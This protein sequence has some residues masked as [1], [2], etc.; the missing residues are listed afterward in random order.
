MHVQWPTQ[1]SHGF[2][3]RNISLNLEAKGELFRSLLTC[4]LGT[5]EARVVFV[6]FYFIL[7]NHVSPLKLGQDRT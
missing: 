1:F 6:L 7:K 3:S 2:A 5:S 4:N